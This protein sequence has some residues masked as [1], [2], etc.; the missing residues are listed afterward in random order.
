MINVISGYEIAG[1]IAKSEKLKK[2][3]EEFYLSKMGE[4]SF[5][6]VDEVKKE[7]KEKRRSP[8]G[9][10]DRLSYQ[11]P[12]LERAKKAFGFQ[13]WKKLSD[14]IGNIVSSS[15]LGCIYRGDYSVANMD[16]WSKIES[17]IIQ[18]EKVIK[19]EKN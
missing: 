11:K 19:N 18:R 12:M 9:K 14:A 15:H 7:K 10:I 17:A 8:Q 1:N 2:E 6:V 16:T 4:I 13:P 5:K 3:V